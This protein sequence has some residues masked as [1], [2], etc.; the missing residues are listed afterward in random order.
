MRINELENRS[1]A[2]IDECWASSLP[3]QHFSISHVSHLL[4]LEISEGKT[5]ENE[6]DAIFEQQ[7]AEHFQN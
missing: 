4:S 5:R 1:E 6:E 3:S 7:M 2:Q